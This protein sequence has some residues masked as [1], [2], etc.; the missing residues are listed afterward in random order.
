MESV[1]WLDGGL[2][3]LIHTWYTTVCNSTLLTNY[4]L[5]IDGPFIDDWNDDLPLE[6]LVILQFANRQTTRG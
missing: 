6:H 2:H 4:P 1:K 3:L 5:V